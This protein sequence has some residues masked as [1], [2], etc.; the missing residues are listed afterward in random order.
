MAE[1]FLIGG[2]AACAAGFLTNPLEVVKTR[3]QLQGELKARGQ[4]R[5]HYRN[6]LHAFLV[7]GRN[8][9]LI[10]LQKGLVP[11]LGFQFC[12]NGIRF[13]LFQVIDNHGLTRD[14]ETGR[15][16]LPR[17]LLSSAVAGATSGLIASPFFLIKV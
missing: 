14:S 10:A 16:L 2:I 9:G 15:V 12:M 8:E 5:K 1:E 7:I 11:A 6:A 3:I 4:Y 17:V 13:G